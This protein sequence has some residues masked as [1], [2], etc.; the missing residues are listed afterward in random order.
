MLQGQRND[1]HRSDY[2]DL[3]L[4][5]D[6]TIAAGATVMS[7]DYVG[8]EWVRNINLYSQS[9]QAH[10]LYLY[11]RGPY[12]AN[13]N[14]APYGVAVASALAATSTSQI[15]CST[16]TGANATLGYTVK[17]GMKNTGASPT[18]FSKLNVELLGL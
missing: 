11:K 8:L 17:F 5:I 3:G 7:S 10:D 9:D 2:E 13:N 14:H 15:R 18:T 16:V 1:F 4:V 6:T 12:G